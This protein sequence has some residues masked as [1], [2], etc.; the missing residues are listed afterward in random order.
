MGTSWRGALEAWLSEVAEVG[1]PPG[2]AVEHGRHDQR[3]GICPK[4][5]TVRSY[6]SHTTTK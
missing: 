5:V 2:V 3:L 6:N 1:C 4:V